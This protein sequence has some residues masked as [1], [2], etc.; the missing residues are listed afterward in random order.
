M[1]ITPFEGNIYSIE[2]NSARMSGIDY[3][4]VRL[5]KSKDMM[6]IKY[7]SQKL[8]FHGDKVKVELPKY[9]NQDG[10]LFSKLV[11]DFWN[12]VTTYKLFVQNMELLFNCFRRCLGGSPRTDWDHIVEGETPSKR[13]LSQCLV[14]IFARLLGED[15]CKNLKEYLERTKNPKT[16]KV[17]QVGWKS[18]TP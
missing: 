15:A 1:I 3:T 7:S 4:P 11:S 6:K 14:A 17:H 9:E 2:S 8:K 10:E 18:L 5:N 16:M 12:M 13:K